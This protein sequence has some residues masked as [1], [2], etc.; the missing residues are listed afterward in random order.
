MFQLR[1]RGDRHGCRCMESVDIHTTEAMKRVPKPPFETVGFRMRKLA[2]SNPI[3]PL[4]A[5]IDHY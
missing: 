1:R 2:L 3:P 5:E 4:W